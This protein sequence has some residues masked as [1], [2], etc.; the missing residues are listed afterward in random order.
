MIYRVHQKVS[1]TEV[2]FDFVTTADAIPFMRD[3][4]MGKV[5][6]DDIEYKVW[7]EIVEEEAD[8]EEESV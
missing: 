8:G 2:T 6:K 7:L 5:S 1:Y 4:T 3:L